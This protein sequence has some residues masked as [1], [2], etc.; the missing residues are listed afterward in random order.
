M[1]QTRTCLRHRE[2][3]LAAGAGLNNRP[4]NLGD[5]LARALDDDSVADAYVL[6]ADVVLVVQRRLAYGDAA[7]LYGLE[8]GER[9]EA[10]GAPDVDLDVQQLGSGLLGGELVGDGPTRVASDEAEMPLVVEAVDLN[11]DAVGLVVLVEAGGQPLPV[12]AADLF[13]CVEPADLRVDS[14]PQ[15]AEPRHD[16]GVGARGFDAFHPTELVYPHVEPALR[17]NTRVELAQRARGAVARVR[18]ERIAPLRAL[19]VELAEGVER[20]VDLAAHLDAGRRPRPGEQRERHGVDGANV[21][22]DVLAPQA[23][24]AGGAAYEPALFVGQRDG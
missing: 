15:L 7:D 21:G 3:R 22:R 19:L 8:D 1:P 10:A 5:D 17:G 18:D 20:H 23:V 9:V 11:D 6:A 2:R 4:D 13:E 24:A 12:V 16:L 14:E